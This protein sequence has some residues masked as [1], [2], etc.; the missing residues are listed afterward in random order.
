MSPRALVSSD[1]PSHSHAESDVTNLV[2]DLAAKEASANKDAANGYAGLDSGAKIAAAQLPNPSAST[3][4]GVK[5]LACT[6]T[7]KLSAIGTDGTPS[8]SADQTGGGGAPIDATYIVQTANG[9]LTAEQAMGALATGLVKNTT[10]TG[11]Q[12]IAVAGT[13]YQ[14]PVSSS[15]NQLSSDVTM[16]TAGTFYN[17]PSL[18]LTAGTYFLSGTVTLQTTSVTAAVQFV[19]KLWDGTTVGASTE[20]VA[21]ATSSAAVKNEPISLSAIVVPTGAATWRIACTSN[22]ASQLI[23][24][25]T[26]QY[27]AGNNASTLVALKIL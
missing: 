9:T 3:L 24:A 2:S 14:A 4:G 17:G 15:V 26:P 22:T 25:A 23:K 12:S 27:G 6:G 11:V 19:C 8:C 20:A 5:S 10:S 16:T 13:D 7:D 18:S 21:G 1:L